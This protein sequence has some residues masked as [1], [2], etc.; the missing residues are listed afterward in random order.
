[1]FIFNDI[2]SGSLAVRSDPSLITVGFKTF[3]L[4][5]FVKALFRI[6]SYVLAILQPNDYMGVIDIK[7]A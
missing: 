1:M 7:S 3:Q 4:I 5:T 6:S 2:M